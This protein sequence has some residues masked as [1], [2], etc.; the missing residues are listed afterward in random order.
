MG[1]DKGLLR[2]LSEKGEKIREDFSEEFLTNPKFAEMI[3]SAVGKIEGTKKTLNKNMR[4]F[5]NTLNLP[6]RSDYK[7]LLGKLDSINMAVSDLES[8]IDDIIAVSE[9]LASQ[10]GS[11]KPKK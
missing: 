10:S 4:F 3:G 6:S 9:K 1:N 7:E 2:R 5:L 8:R 11:A